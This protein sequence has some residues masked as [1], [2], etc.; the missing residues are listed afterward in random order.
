MTPN[1]LRLIDKKDLNKQ[2]NLTMK[3]FPGLLEKYNTRSLHYH[4]SFFTNS[5]FKRAWHELPGKDKRLL[6]EFLKNYETG[7]LVSS[8]EKWNL[9]KTQNNF[10]KTLRPIILI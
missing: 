1:K 4:R 7:P 8:E 5:Y 2:R 10:R 6:S 9:L 3:H